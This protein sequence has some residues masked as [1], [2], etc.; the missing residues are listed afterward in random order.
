[1]AEPSHWSDDSRSRKMSTPQITAN[2]G[3]PSSSTEVSI[4]GNRGSAAPISS[5]PITRDQGDAAGRW[6]LTIQEP[7]SACDE[8]H[9]HVRDDRAEARTKQCDRLVPEIQ[10]DRENDA[11][12]DGHPSLAPRPPIAPP[13]R[14]PQY[15]E[16]RQ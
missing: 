15:P 9:L 11:A 13:L 3:W 16:D 1:M 10:V 14:Q 12:G 2:T 6:P 4:A 5:Q 7:R 8:H